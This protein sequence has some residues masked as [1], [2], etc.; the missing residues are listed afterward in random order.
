[1]S[2]LKYLGRG[3]LGSITRLYNFLLRILA[4]I[5]VLAFAGALFD[6]YLKDFTPKSINALYI[7]GGV[8]VFVALLFWLRHYT[9]FKLA[10]REYRQCL[11]NN[12]HD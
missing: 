1:M 2:Y 9:R 3:G 6:A 10:E 5:L 8:C 7:V 12:Q 11:N 4:K